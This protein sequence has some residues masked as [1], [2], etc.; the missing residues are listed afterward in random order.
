MFPTFRTLGPFALSVSLA[1]VFR[2][3][4]MVVL[5]EGRLT[6]KLRP[7]SSVFTESRKSGFVG[8]LFEIVGASRVIVLT[9]WKASSLIVL[10]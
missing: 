3:R 10:T 9:V 8:S 5:F 7:L 1:Q 2:L 4:D 6:E